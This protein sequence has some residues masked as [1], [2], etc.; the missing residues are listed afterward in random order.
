MN[1]V[2]QSPAQP[3]QVV[4]VAYRLFRVLDHNT[5]EILAMTRGETRQCARKTG[6]IEIRAIQSWREDD[7]LARGIFREH[8]QKITDLM[9]VPD[10]PALRRCL[11]GG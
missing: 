10:D 4:V 7:D 2:A 1:E 8:H 9:A 5:R 11:G 3:D 6:S